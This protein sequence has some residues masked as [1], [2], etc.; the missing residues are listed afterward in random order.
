MFPV[1]CSLRVA[2]HLGED[3][4][5][6]QRQATPQEI[7]VM[8]ARERLGPGYKPSSSL[9]AIIA[10]GADGAKKAIA[11][12]AKTQ[13]MTQL[14]VMLSIQ[15]MPVWGQVTAGLLVLGQKIFGAKCAN[16]VKDIVNDRIAGLTAY[17]EAKNKELEAAAT[18]AA[19][20][21]AGTARVLAGSKQP[22]SLD[23]RDFMTVAFVPPPMRPLLITVDGLGSI[24]PW[25]C[26]TASTR[27]QM[28]KA[29]R[30]AQKAISETVDPIVAETKK[31]GFRAF[32]AKVMAIQLR[33]N[34]PEFYPFA[35]TFDGAPKDGLSTASSEAT[36]PATKSK[37]AL[38]VGGGAAAAL[39]ALVAAR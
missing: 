8:A 35:V 22:L 37:T 29:V 14:G 31:D 6:S 4:A 19:N 11:D 23:Q 32:M 1:H 9:Q 16:K 17:A 30:E 27:Q 39:L 18:E 28:D 10:N 36:A 21:V 15:A 3:V 12:V 38:I 33:W 34:T 7:M 25:E 20:Y 26:N 13:A 24:I 2:G 5:Q